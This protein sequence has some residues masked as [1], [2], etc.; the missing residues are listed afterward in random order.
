MAKKRT[1]DKTLATKLTK[2]AQVALVEAF[3]VTNNVA[4]AATLAGVRRVADAARFL[5]S[6]E[7]EQAIRLA[8]RAAGLS[9]GLLDNTL[10]DILTDEHSTDDARVKAAKI[11]YERVK[12]K[13]EQGNRKPTRYDEL[14]FEEF[15]KLLVEAGFP[16]HDTARQIAFGTIPAIQVQVDL[17][18]TGGGATELARPPAIID[19]NAT[20]EP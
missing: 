12:L 9:E 15:V 2:D 19:V 14:P 20:R 1:T 10:V 16:M 13:K 8:H 18:I 5:S 17:R 6:E 7:G 11:G 3:R 4:D